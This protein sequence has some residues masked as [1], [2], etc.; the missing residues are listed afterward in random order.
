MSN[1]PDRETLAR[2]ER[3]Y[4]LR[5]ATLSRRR[6][7]GLTLGAGA[8][9]I[10]SA[11]LAA[12]G[13]SSSLSGDVATESSGGSSGS[14]STAAAASTSASSSGTMTTGSAATPGSTSAATGAKPAPTGQV[15]VGLSQEPTVFNPLMPGIE[16]DQGVHWSVFSPL[17]GVNE[18]GEFFPQLAKEVPTVENGGISADGLNFKV[19]LRDDVKWHDGEPFSADDVKFTHDLIMSPDFRADSRIGH[20]LVTDMTVVSPTEITWKMKQPYAPYL[21]VLSWTFIV[22]QHILS[23]EADPNKAAFNQKPVGTGAYMWQDRTPGDHITLKAN[24]NFFGEGPFIET[25]VV[26]YIPDL[27]VL[28]TQFK[29]GAIDFTGIQGITA[30][31]YN[32]AKGLTDRQVVVAPANSI[33]SINL[34]MGKPQ[35]QD[36]AVRQAL[37]YAMDKD[38]IIEKIYYGVQGHT[39]TFLPQQSWAFNPDLPKHEYNPDK[40]KQLLDDAGWKVGSDGVREKNGVKLAFSNSTTAGNHV[41]EQAQAFLQQNWKDI[42]VAMEIKNMPAAV[43]WGDYFLKS[44]YDTVMVGIDFMSGADP[45]STVRF[46]SKDIPAQGG[47]GSNTMQYKNPKVDELFDKGTTTIKQEDRKPIYQEIQKIIR[48]DLPLLPMFQY[49]TIVG[50]N[51]G[52][53]GYVPNLNVLSNYWRINA[54]KWEK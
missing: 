40:A 18:K 44:Q 54:W 43:I 35:F 27:T 5:N 52:L 22:P 47:S 4:G 28:Y 2:M 33:E 30:D 36:L 14:A 24:P 21:A 37:Y 17:W 19:T 23:K 49:S 6:L 25:Q 3:V 29:T 51:K 48:D 26:K 1:K 32:E 39:E 13:G 11:L 20:E 42:G 10:G 45:D 7:L 31:H 16:V 53:T 50:V 12:C 41:R 46:S 34:N 8:A 38:T 9:T 15:I